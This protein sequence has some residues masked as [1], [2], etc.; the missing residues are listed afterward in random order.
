[1]GPSVEEAVAALLSARL[2][3]IGAVEGEVTWLAALR[4]L[5]RPSSRKKSFLILIQEIVGVWKRTKLTFKAVML[6]EYPKFPPPALLI[7]ITW[8]GIATGSSKRLCTSSK[9]TCYNA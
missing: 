5:P 2:G 1:L 6:A 8:Y 3:P 4:V 9:S 7:K